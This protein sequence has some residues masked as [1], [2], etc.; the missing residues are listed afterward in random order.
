LKRTNKT[1]SA[2]KKVEN[3]FKFLIN[4][5]GYLSLLA[6]RIYPFK[7]KP[8]EQINHY[9]DTEQ[10]DLFASNV[11]LKIREYNH[12]EYAR[13]FLKTTRGNELEQRA[14][15]SR[16]EEVITIS[17]ESLQQYLSAQ[18]V[19]PNDLLFTQ[20]Y[21]YDELV[22]HKTVYF[23]GDVKTHRHEIA[24]NEMKICLDCNTYC[25]Q[26]DYEIE[27]EA[28]Q[29][30]GYQAEIFQFLTK[31]NI[32]YNPAQSKRTRFFQTIRQNI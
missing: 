16:N 20:L 22:Q 18:K 17:H 2:E 3:E 21:S 13:I 27:F 29:I 19:L 6:Q 23:W 4:K 25:N 32:E 30:L 7:D 31:N 12:R 9:F 1:I 28:N 14:Y 8:K 26:T 10:F 5:N 24:V 11:T 15:K